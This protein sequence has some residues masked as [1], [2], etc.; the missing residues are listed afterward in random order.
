MHVD[1]ELSSVEKKRFDGLES[2]LDKA[3]LCFLK[4]V[5]LLE[6][7]LNGLNGYNESRLR[8]RLSNLE[9]LSGQ[10]KS[11]TIT[12][13][14]GKDRFWL[15]LITPSVSV[16]RSYQIP[17]DQLRQ[18][19]IKFRSVLE[20]PLAD[21]RRQAKELYQIIISP[22][23]ND[24]KQLQSTELLWELNGELSYLPVNTLYDGEKYFIE[25]YTNIMVDSSSNI[26]P[27]RQ[28]ELSRI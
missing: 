10:L 7:D 22:I 3:R 6:N 8:E 19:V 18:K 2:D 27:N 20:N 28:F 12:T 11:N 4:G 1:H 26:L 9:S 17:H 14:A 15:I 23:E 5:E 24:L 25:R 21:P 13:C 16:I